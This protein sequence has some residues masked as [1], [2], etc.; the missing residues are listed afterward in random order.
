MEIL[1]SLVVFLGAVIIHEFAHAWVA[2][3]L[4]DRTAK[5][6]GRLT[7]NPLAHVDP[8]GTIVLPLILVLTKAPVLF[9][10][11]KPVPVNFAN[12]GNPRKDMVWVG[13]A[14]PGVNLLA[15]IA[16]SFVLK[17]AAYLPGS[18]TYA[19][20]KFLLVNVALGVFNLFPIPPLDGSRVLMGLAPRILARQI[21]RIE[22]YGFVLL[23]TL[24]Y[25][26]LFERVLWPVIGLIMGLLLR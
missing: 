20:V 12:L 7:L 9:G 11:A 21:A 13:L 23:F 1:I 6:S 22:P 14:G 8:F 19:L 3:L 17:F 5:D 2:N 18:I 26:G 15:A 10:W 24:L 16:C 4:G 25:L